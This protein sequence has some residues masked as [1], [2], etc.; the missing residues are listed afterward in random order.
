[1]SIMIIFATPS[2]AKRYDDGLTKSQRESLCTQL[3]DQSRSAGSYGSDILGGGVIPDNVLTSIF[4]T[5][6]KIS[7]STASLLALGHSLMCHAVHAGRHSIKLLGIELFSFPD[8][9]VWLCGLIIYFVGFMMTLSISFYVADIAFKLG[10]AVIMLPIAIALWPFPVTKDKLSAIISII[11]NNAGIFIFLSLTVS[12]AL[13]LI[14]A[15]VSMDSADGNGFAQIFNLIDNNQTDL[16]AENFTIFSTFFLVM[17]FALVYGFKLIGSAIPDYANKFFPD[18]GTGGASPIHDSMTQG[19]DFVKKNTVD[20][21]ASYAGDV[22]KTQTGRVMAGTGKFVAGGYNKQIK[23]YMRNPG[24]IGKNIAHS[25]HNFGGNVTKGAASVLTGTV[26]RI[27]MGKEA[28]EDLKNKLH[29]KIDQGTNYLNE[30]ADNVAQNQN[31]RV[32]NRQNARQQRWK[33]RKEDFNNS[34]IGKR[35]NQVGA[36]ISNRHSKLQTAYENK[37]NSYKQRR[38]EIA[39]YVEKK[40]IIGKLAKNVNTFR[41]GDEEF[42]KKLE[43]APDFDIKKVS[44]ADYRKAY[45]YSK[46]VDRITNRIIQTRNSRRDMVNDFVLPP[47]KNGNKVVEGAKSLVR[48]VHKVTNGAVTLGLNAATATL[49][50]AAK[51]TARVATGVAATPATVVTAVAKTPS[52]IKEG[53]LRA[54]NVTKNAKHIFNAGKSAGKS[55]V[56]FT[57][58]VLEKTG[59]EMQKNKKSQS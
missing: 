25:V 35:I 38:K 48:G 44:D 57:G 41:N 5:T 56:K 27:A 1:M 42:R 11:L 30:K 17:M 54:V 4:S 36:Q 7:D 8:I 33:Q 50:G 26:G 52:L 10:F 18:N 51:L 22:V 15:A 14:S 2:Y 9:S 31:T 21:V 55:A 37:I 39:D 40:T 45:G 43:S 46:S 16:I 32:H 24:D 47:N 29:A 23:H 3:K 19:M 58:E 59:H 28:S 34:D 12:Y 20:K 6:K 13:N 49:G 53:G